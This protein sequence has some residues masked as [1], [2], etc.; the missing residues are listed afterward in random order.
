MYKR[1]QN[2]L[3]NSRSIK[4]FGNKE[5]AD[6]NRPRRRNFPVFAALGTRTEWA[7]ADSNGRL[8]R[9]KRG[10]LTT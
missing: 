5:K 7:M 2:L 9:C 10:A 4:S 1:G 3:Q 8:P 6:V